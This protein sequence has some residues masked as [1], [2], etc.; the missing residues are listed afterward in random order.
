MSHMKN[1]SLNVI[2]YCAHAFLRALVLAKLRSR[3]GSV[4]VR[5]GLFNFRCSLVM[6]RLTVVVG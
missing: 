1:E 2:L 6:D 3:N 5:S 4:H